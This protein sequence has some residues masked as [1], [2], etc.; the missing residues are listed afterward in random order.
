MDEFSL[1][2][3]ID[4]LHP[5]LSEF[6]GPTALLDAWTPTG[7]G[8]YHYCFTAGDFFGL[9]A[10]K[11]IYVGATR[12]P[13]ACIPQT[14]RPW[15]PR[16]THAVIDRINCRHH[17]GAACSESELNATARLINSWM[18]ETFRPADNLALDSVI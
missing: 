4:P 15:W 3:G 8:I 10:T 11:I 17:G 12:N 16:V 1:I 18:I 6:R 5:L 14:R 9:A 13:G 2:A 7:P